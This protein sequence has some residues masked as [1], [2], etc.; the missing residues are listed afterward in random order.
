[1]ISKII[2]F[3][4][5]TIISLFMIL[6]FILFQG[7][8][9]VVFGTLFDQTIFK[10]F[11]DPTS[12]TTANKLIVP[13]IGTLSIA[14]LILLIVF[15]LYE[16]FLEQKTFGL[17]IVMNI[18]L[19][20]SIVVFGL[21]FY[22]YIA[23]DNII[24]ESNP[25]TFGETKVTSLVFNIALSGTMLSLVF[26][27]FV[28]SNVLWFPIVA[29]KFRSSNKSFSFKPKKIFN[30]KEKQSIVDED[31]DLDE[32]GMGSLQPG[33]ERNEIQQR[34]VAASHGRVSIDEF[35]EVY[36]LQLKTQLLTDSSL[37]PYVEQPKQPK[38]ET[39]IPKVSKSDLE[40]P[41]KVD[42]DVE[43]IFDDYERRLK[44][45]NEPIS[46]Q[47]EIVQNNNLDNGEYFM[48]RN[49][50]VNQNQ[51]NEDPFF[52]ASNNR[53]KNNTIEQEDLLRDS[54]RIKQLLEPK[55]NHAPA[56]VQPAVVKKIKKEK[57][58]E[59]IHALPTEIVSTNLTQV[60]DPLRNVDETITYNDIRQ[61]NTVQIRQTK[62]DTEPLY[63]TDEVM[64][65]QEI[66]QTIQSNAPEDTYEDT[67]EI[68]FNRTVNQDNK[69]KNNED[70]KPQSTSTI[71]WDLD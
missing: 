51:V 56:A 43:K 12:I 26:I 45:E 34:K 50:V 30:K 2:K 63:D 46:P 64:V 52:S 9:G 38:Y 65:S 33:L 3:T 53:V 23:I 7:D 35:E 39:E 48:P 49:R 27:L 60:E 14:L 20:I 13:L 71:D 40:I 15:Y 28:Y 19:F 16:A 57:I 61:N 8:D 18:V 5:L 4:L 55:R 37:E 22:G 58:K 21:Y 42:R 36:G 17:I 70:T 54:E 25:L 29:D 6:P 41:T 10:D 66:R 11:G 47:R 68:I 24:G 62:I 69:D 32:D 67:D 44:D 1:M 31:E 59:I